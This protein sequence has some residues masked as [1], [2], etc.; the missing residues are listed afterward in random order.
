MVFLIFHQDFKE[1]D[2][3]PGHPF[4][5]ERVKIFEKVIKEKFKDFKKLRPEPAGDEDLELIC[6]KDYIEFTKNYFSARAKGKDFN[7]RFF[8]YHSPDNLPFYGCGNIEKAARLIIGGVK[9]AVEI[10]CRRPDILH[11]PTVVS[12][13]GLHHAKPSFGEGFCIYNDVA[14]AGKYLVEKKKF[15]R[16]LILD[17]DAH[18]GNGT[19]EYFWKEKRVLFIDLH[20][21]PKTLYPGTGFA[22]EIGEEE[23]KGYTLNIPLPP[24]ASDSSYELV[25]EEII[26]P[27][28]E[29]FKP[30]IILRNG[31]SDPHFADELTNLGLT[32]KGFYFIGKKVREFREK[33]NIPTIDLLGSG[34]NLKVLPYAW[35]VLIEG[36]AGKERKIFKEPIPLPQ[37][38]K[39]DP[40]FLETKKLVKKI[41][42]IF[43]GIWF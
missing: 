37:Y 39:K 11:P 26:A 21:D 40:V 38:V 7:G 5:G 22:E 41:K 19:C 2:F 28:V 9:L 12:F 29:K 36:L 27:V 17:T 32:L 25:F 8:K 43:K 20:Q 4:R 34:Y 42:D 18:A 1:Y 33:L 31:G 30:Q 13:G 14:F 16:V 15:N 24:S 23:G 3:G 35:S 10:I 6:E